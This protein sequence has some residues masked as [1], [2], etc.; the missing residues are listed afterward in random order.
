NMLL[1]QDSQAP[2]ANWKETVKLV[3]SGLDV[4][5]VVMGLVRTYR[6]R[7][8][9]KIGAT[10]A[11]VGFEVHLV[12]PKSGKIY[13]TGEYYEEQKPMTEDFMGFVE[14]GGVF[15][16]AHE[17]AEYGVHKMMKQFPVG[18]TK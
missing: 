5:A 18:N 2:T 7:V 17:L 13:W 6:E 4:D 3:G 12:D 15:V 8:G 10:P 11:S 1:T 14:R 9:T 16:T